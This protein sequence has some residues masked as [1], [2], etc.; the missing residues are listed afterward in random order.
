MKRTSL[1][2]RLSHAWRVFSDPESYARQNVT[3]GVSYGYRPDRTRLTVGNERSIISSV[4]NR[5]AIDASAI[6]IQHIRV[7]EHGRF[8]E[9]IDSGLNRCLNLEANIDQ[10]GKAFIQ[11][12]VMSMFDEGAIALVPIDTTENPT[13]T[14]SYDVTSLRVGKI[15]EWHPQHVR[16]RV[17]NDRT[18]LYE[19]LL[20]SKRVA[21]IIENPLYAVM[22]EP[23]ST[24]KRL[25]AKLNIL[26]AIDTQSGSGKIDLIIQLPYVIKSQARRDEADRR[27]A[28]IEKQLTDSRYGVAYTD[29]TEKITQLNR[30]AENNLMGQIEFLTSMLYSQLGLTNEI[31]DGTA[32]ETAIINYYNRTV[33]PVVSSLADGIKRTFLTKTARS[34]GQT[35]GYFRDPFT[36]VAALDLAEIADKLTRNAILSS[37][38]LRSIMGYKPDKSPE[39]DE[40]RNKNINPPKEEE[41]TKK[42]AVVPLELPKIKGEKDDR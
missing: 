4:Y 27:R 12:A 7:D 34:Q 40:L 11:D 39:S 5:I 2:D 20:M 28:D 33:G 26:D 41:E 9:E 30:P 22:N 36:L 14:G 1:T 23:N 8:S 25:I 3:A 38:D 42:P 13:I 21:A 10:S 24:L 35:I 6:R 15:I 18:G 37:N 32:D 16:V 17:Y 19:D 29:G 31:F